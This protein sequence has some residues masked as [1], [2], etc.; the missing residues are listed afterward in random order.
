M[1]G[2]ATGH[3]VAAFFTGPLTIAI[4]AMTLF[5]LAYP[6]LIQRLRKIRK[7]NA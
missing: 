2:S 5:S 7:G 6:L 1:I 3:P 4:I